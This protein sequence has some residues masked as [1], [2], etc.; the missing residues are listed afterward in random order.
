MSDNDKLVC[1]MTKYELRAAVRGLRLRLSDMTQEHDRLQK[2]LR[3]SDPSGSRLAHMAESSRRMKVERELAE[4][5]KS[6]GAVADEA[7]RLMGDLADMKQ[8][9]IS[10]A[11]HREAMR[12]AAV[13][14]VRELA[15]ARRQVGRSVDELTGVLC[16]QEGACC[17]TGSDGDRQI[18]DNVLE[19]LRDMAR[20]RTVKAAQA[21]KDVDN[22]I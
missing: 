9:S 4:A 13:G 10:M 22:G 18:V 20:G 5:R 21:G 14:Y 17:I 19:V 16:N 11:D 7:L 8:A 1:D 3:L 6:L 2:E 12:M 15:E